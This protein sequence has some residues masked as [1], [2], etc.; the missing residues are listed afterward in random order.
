M[1]C[2]V[3]VVLL[4]WETVLRELE[5]KRLMWQVQY[6]CIIFCTPTSLRRFTTPRFTVFPSMSNCSFLTEFI[7]RKWSPCHCAFC[8]FSIDLS[9]SSPIM[10]LFSHCFLSSVPVPFTLTVASSERHDKH[11]LHLRFAQLRV[12]KARKGKFHDSICEMI[13]S[14]CTQDPRYM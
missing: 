9:L 10:P 4:C 11:V 7:V 8:S 1:Y 13:G 2:S 14:L 12:W 6:P 5:K 3:D